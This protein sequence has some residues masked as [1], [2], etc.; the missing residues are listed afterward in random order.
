MPT[1][2]RH[3]ELVSRAH[4]HAVSLVFAPYVYSLIVLFQVAYRVMSPVG[5]ATHYLGRNSHVLPLPRVHDPPTG[6]VGY[7]ALGFVILHTYRSRHVARCGGVGFRS[8]AF[9]RSSLARR[10]ARAQLL[11]PLVPASSVV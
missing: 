2:D 10:S 8:Y 1:E 3:T 7:A 11:P 4:G 9:G 6:G 5:L